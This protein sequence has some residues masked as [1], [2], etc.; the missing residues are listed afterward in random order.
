M[1]TLVAYFSR[2][3]ENYGVGDIV[4]GNTEV[5]AE[6]VAAKTG[7]RLFRIRTVNEYPKDYKRCTELAREE[8]R[9]KVRPEF[10]GVLPDVS[11]YDTVFLGYPNWW[12]DLPMAVYAFLEALD[13]SEKTIVPFC[14]HEGSGLSGTAETIRRLCPGAEVLDGFEV[15]GRFC[16]G[17]L[18][19]MEATVES[20]LAKVPHLA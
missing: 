5:V 17:S 11:E 6:L 19:K 3:G 2:A 1:G 4:K 8:Q 14:T 7:A 13:F 10:L 9:R 12:G 15:R 16:Q 18:G 20:G